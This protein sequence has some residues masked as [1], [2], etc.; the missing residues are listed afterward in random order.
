MLIN[1]LQGKSITLACVTFLM[2]D[3]VDTSQ[4]AL[5]AEIGCQP[6]KRQL[7]KL[8]I[9]PLTH[10]GILFPTDI[11]AYSQRSYFLL[12]KHIN[13]LTA[14]LVKHIPEMFIS[15]CIQSHD[16][17]C[18]SLDTLQILYGLQPCKFLVEIP[19]V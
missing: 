13:N 19:I 2:L 18:T 7:N 11:V 4:L 6:R 1:R 16:A 5:V 9:V 8:L 15:L 12:N 10:V 17:F 3:E 14:H